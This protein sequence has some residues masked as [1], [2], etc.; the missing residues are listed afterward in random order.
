MIL[1]VEQWMIEADLYRHNKELSEGPSIEKRMTLLT[2]I[3]K[4]RELLQRFA[5]EPRMEAR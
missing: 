5:P 2:L 4:K 3:E 1:V